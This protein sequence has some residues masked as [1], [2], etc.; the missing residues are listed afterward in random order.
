MRN[1]GHGW[2]RTSRPSSRLRCKARKGRTSRATLLQERDK[3]HGSANGHGRRLVLLPVW[4]SYQNVVQNLRDKGL[5]EG[6]TI[7]SMYEDRKG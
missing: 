1:I 6:I 4:D 5:T 3:L 2:P 7:T